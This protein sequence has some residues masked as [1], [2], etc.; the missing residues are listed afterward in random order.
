M[1]TVNLEET[2]KSV[3]I[4]TMMKRDNSAISVRD[5]FSSPGL[6]SWGSWDMQIAIGM[7]K[8]KMSPAGGPEQHRKY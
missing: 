2:I 6:V 4:S 3:P 5:E 1:S 8:S 7:E